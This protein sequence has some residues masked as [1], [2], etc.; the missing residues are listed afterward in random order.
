M[1]NDDRRD[2]WDGPPVGVA[3]RLRHLRRIATAETDGEARARL[4]RERPAPRIST[5][6]ELA[7]ARLRE[8]R[9][10]CELTAH[11]HRAR[12]RTPPPRTT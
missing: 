3:A 7:S 5:F 12:Q 2:V 8:L 1:S 10:L 9:A 4:A 6:A 11:L